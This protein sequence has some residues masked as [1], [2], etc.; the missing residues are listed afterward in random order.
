MSR[1]VERLCRLLLRIY[2]RAFRKSYGS[3]VIRALADDLRDAQAANRGRSGRWT[4]WHALNAGLGDLILAGLAERIRHLARHE[5]PLSFETARSTRKNTMDNLQ[6]DFRFAFRSLTKSPGATALIVVVLA[7]GIGANTALFSVVDAVLLSPLPYPQPEELVMVWGAHRESGKNRWW[8]SYPDFVDFEAQTDVF[9]EMAAFATPRV[10]L[11]GPEGDPLR[12]PAARVTYD[13]FDV[14]G[15]S[16]ASGRAFLPEEDRVGGEPAVILSHG[17]WQRRFSG[18]P[19]I[20]ERAVNVNGLPHAVVGVMPPGF[21]YPT[22]SEVWLPALPG[23]GRDSRGAHRLRVLA[24]LAPATS[25]EAATTEMRAVA[26]RLED[27]YPKSNTNR[28]AWVQPLHEARVGRVATALWIL[29]GAVGLVLLVACA[30]VANLLLGRLVVRSHELALRATLGAT[31]WRLARQLLTESLM[32]AVIGGVAGWFVSH[33][34]LRLLIAASPVNLPRIEEVAI[35]GR[36]L[37]ATAAASLAAGVVF[38]SVPALR[39]SRHDLQSSLRSGSRGATLG[40]SRPRLR[41]MLVTVEIAL[42]VVLVI[43]AGLLVRSFSRLTAVDPGFD[44]DQVLT[45]RLSLPTDSKYGRG[46]QV[47]AFYDR[48]TERLSALP[49]VRSVS[50]AHAHPL[51]PS[52]TST[53]AIEGILELPEGERPEANFRPVRPGYFETMGIALIEG[54]TLD[55]RDS[56]EAPGAAVVNQ[57]FAR[58]FFGDESPVGHRLSW[59]NWYPGMPSSFEIVGVSAD[60]RFHGLGTES[61]WAMYFPHAQ[62]PISD[63]YLLLKTETEP[64]TLASAVRREVWA[65]DADLPV[66]GLRTMEE[67]VAGSVGEPRFQMQLMGSFAG[68]AL[69]LAAVGVFGVISQAVS[70]R[71]GEIGLRLALGARRRQVFHMV[72]GEGLRLAV[73]GILVGLAAAWWAVRVLGP[74]LYEVETTDPWTFGAV[75]LVLGGVVLA[76]T[77][78]PARRAMGVDPIVALRHE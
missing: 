46:V 70:R 73:A 10:N 52:W 57:T 25:I 61:Q 32:L 65:L 33:A 41:G 27:A 8:T 66:D 59:D 68:L 45:L 2:P 78:W 60:V 6:Q 21:Q 67:I 43:G 17:L 62:V 58:T 69:L 7:L 36:V 29:F 48:L 77:S 35:D 50:A 54:R 20:L 53:F 26:Q 13:F 71:T 51:D 39:A 63:L 31:R 16:P 28:T 15:V 55:E 14:L 42:A 75:A 24:R 9:R 34:L 44:A 19:A 76:A 74:L 11:V 49:G 38:G 64:L 1:S 22:G 40:L 23:Y 56:E 18:D 4:R 5:P 72:L 3:E 30:N 12:L 47:R 37:L